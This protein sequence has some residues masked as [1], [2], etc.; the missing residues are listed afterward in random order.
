M[1]LPLSVWVFNN[2][3]KWAFFK[4]NMALVGISEWLFS[5]LIIGILSGLVSGIIIMYSQKFSNNL[6]KVIWVA[7]LLFFIFF[8]MMT[9]FVIFWNWIMIPFFN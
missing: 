3:F 4:K 2:I 5:A 9:L 7:I 1:P 6:N 8:F